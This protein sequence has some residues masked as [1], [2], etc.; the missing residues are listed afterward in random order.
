[1]DDERLAFTPWKCVSQ[2]LH[3]A[4]ESLVKAKPTTIINTVERLQKLLPEQRI[5][6]TTGTRVFEIDTGH[7]VM[8]LEPVAL[9]E[10]LLSLA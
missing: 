6:N 10:M 9:A 7:D 3:F 8:I 4:N 2:P 5:R 1:M